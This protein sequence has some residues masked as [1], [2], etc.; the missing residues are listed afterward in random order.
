MY[1]ILDLVVDGGDR[2]GCLSHP[3]GR[4]TTLEVKMTPT[5]GIWDDPVRNLYDI[6]GLELILMYRGLVI[7]CKGS[8]T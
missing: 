5:K 4:K 3:G 8:P 7:I 2:L 6:P 1:V